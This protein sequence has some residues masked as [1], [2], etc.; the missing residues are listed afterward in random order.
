[1]LI[2]FCNN[3]MAIAFQVNAQHLFYRIL[4][5]EPGTDQQ[6]WNETALVYE[7]IAAFIDANGEPTDRVLAIDPPKMF[8]L[9]GYQS[10]ATP[11]DGPTAAA[12]V[13]VDFE[14]QWLVLDERF[15]DYFPTMYP[16]G[17]DQA[18]WRNVAQFE[19]STGDIVLLFAYEPG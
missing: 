19:E 10:L 1:M 7:Q 14:A 12:N 6:G 13:A 5:H 17:A 8:A 4:A 18:G 15:E 2:K 11:W 9:T 3:V 16:G